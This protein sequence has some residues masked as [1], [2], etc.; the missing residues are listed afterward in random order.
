[1][2]GVDKKF[3]FS[4]VGVMKSFTDP[5]SDLNV[6]YRSFEQVF[7]VNRVVLAGHV[8]AWV[9]S[10]N[11]S[12]ALVL[13]PGFM[14]VAETSFLYVQALA[15]PTRRVMSLTYPNTIDKVVSLCDGIRD[16]L[17]YI[18]IQRATFLGGSSSGFIAQAFLRYYPERVDALILSHT[19]LPLLTRAHT[20]R[21]YLE[22]L[23]LLPYK[24]VKWL[25]KISVYLYF[26]GV[27]SEHIFWRNHFRTVLDHLEYEGLRS[28]FALMENFHRQY[29]FV[30]GDLGD[31]PGRILLLEMRK[32][33]LTNPVEQASLRALYPQARVHSFD[34]TAH[35]DSVDYPDEQIEIIRRF[36]ED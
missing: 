21:I 1:M 14:G 2:F 8:W 7:P 10:V 6:V 27:I 31:W 9:D 34:E 28:R 30:A 17:D 13:L 24:L 18:G 15:S 32:D 26:P 33:K 23:R 20:A 35:F 25:M 4:G 5:N 16:F 12:E 29:S 19:G 22:T 36:V 3:G 11:G